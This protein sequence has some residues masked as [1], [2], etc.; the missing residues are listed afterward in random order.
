[1]AQAFRYRARVIKTGR[2]LGESMV[3]AVLGKESARMTRP[4]FGSGSGLGCGGRGAARWIQRRALVVGSLQGRGAIWQIAAAGIARDRRD[5]G[6][7]GSN[8]IDRARREEGA[9]MERGGTWQA[10]DVAPAWSFYTF[11]CG[12]NGEDLDALSPLDDHR[13]SS[14]PL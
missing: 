11:H 8:E 4:G 7:M 1:M 13:G 6:R 14:L 10:E 5:A 2:K 3:M 12:N 9:T